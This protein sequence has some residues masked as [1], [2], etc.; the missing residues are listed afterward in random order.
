[1]ARFVSVLVAGCVLLT[2]FAVSA[3]AANSD[4][5]TTIHIGMNGQKEV[6]G[7]GDPDG[8]GKAVLDIDTATDE[9][10]FTVT[11]RKI[12]E[13]TRAHIHAGDKDTAGGIVVTLW[14]GAG[15]FTRSGC[16]AADGAVLDAI[17]ASPHDYYVNVHNAPHPGGAL[18]GQL[19]PGS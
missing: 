3:V 4:D 1:M 16:V 7:P 11:T 9:V 13:P 5:V 18:R 12:E 14:E 6:P 15:G 17:V 19:H 10:C 2:V 8:S